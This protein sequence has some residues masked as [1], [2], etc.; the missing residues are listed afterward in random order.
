MVLG[1]LSL[2]VCGLLGPV[3]IALYFSATKEI[4]RGGYTRGSKTMAQAGLVMGVISTL[5]LLG[6]VAL[7]ILGEI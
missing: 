6:V 4:S 3:A 5:L 7:G 2:V 1:I